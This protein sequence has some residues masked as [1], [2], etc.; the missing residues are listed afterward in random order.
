MAGGKV[1]CGGCGNAFNAL[2]YL[3][4][5]RP[6]APAAPPPETEALPELKPDVPEEPADTPPAAISP[7][8]SAALLK[9]LDQ[10]AGEDIRIEDTGI[11]WRILD[12]DEEPEEQVDEVLDDSPTPVD[13]FLTKTPTAVDA[14][15]IF[16]Q[17]GKPAP[18]TSVEE[19]RF[20]D[21]TGLPDD[22]DLDDLPSPPPAAPE[23]K[24]EPEP[25]PEPMQQQVDLAFGDP[26]EW[27]ELLQ[28]VDTSLAESTPTELVPELSEDMIPTGDTG[29]Q[30]SPPDLDTQFNLQAEAMGID[31]GVHATVDEAEEDTS[32]DDDLIAAAFEKEQA[33]SRAPSEPED[34]A[35][36]AAVEAAD[37]E[38]E[39]EP[40]PAM[41][42]L[43]EPEIE[44]QAIDSGLEELVAEGNAEPEYDEIRVRM[45]DEPPLGETEHEIPEPTEEEMT[46]NLQIDADL[47]AIAVEDDDGFA[48]T[49]VIED[50][51]KAD[52]E[53]EALDLQLELE[54]GAAD[55]HEDSDEESDEDDRP[56][57]ELPFDEDTPGVETIIMEG[58]V[59]S[60]ALDRERAAAEHSAKQPQNLSFMEAA[61]RT[62]RGKFA[63]NDE[64]PKAGGRRYGMIA[65][66]VLLAA[67]LVV[68][69][70]HQSR[71][72]LATV[73]AVND[74]I[75][76]LYRA[77]G[78]PITPEWDV[79]GWRFE[80]SVGTTNPLEF[81]ESESG[82]VS[83]DELDPLADII[84]EGDEVLT[85]YSRV[86]NKSDGP[87]PYPLISVALTDRF[88]ETIGS[89][90]LEPAEYL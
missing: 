80:K 17:P 58:D 57:T 7:E 11:E 1:R 32:I 29:S 33:A 50:K 74:I 88:E 16:E 40:H 21:D 3:S 31:T 61:K 69:F 45:D 85:I 81:A 28:E 9:T 2:A 6:E 14:G 41:A 55:E 26:D 12:K 54:G 51:K 90:V 78:A 75:A 63:A 23:P 15:E 66:V 72:A 10:L 36:A 35:A 46:V 4:E 30:A 25:E 83:L 18:Q 65:A 20:D 60:A 84:A 8:Q 77:I 79:T 59:V 48:S 67:L 71:T 89:I 27:G 64:E 37:E 56:V 42:E 87:L 19:L 49:I 5:T 82:E 43:A 13:E 47:M 62:M 53:E 73:P 44:L 34:E 68:Q 39:A 22:F 86:G 52:V 38:D 76:P 24:P 70:V